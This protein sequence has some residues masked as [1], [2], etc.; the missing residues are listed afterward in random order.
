MW[1]N[2]LSLIIAPCFCSQHN[3]YKSEVPQTKGAALK[4][5]RGNYYAKC[6]IVS[7]YRPIPLL[8]YLKTQK[9]KTSMVVNGWNESER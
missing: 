1:T 4:C 8:A 3:F 7:N 9:E 2:L 6:Q 5:Y